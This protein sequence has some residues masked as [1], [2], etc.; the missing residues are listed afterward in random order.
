MSPSHTESLLRKHLPEIS[1][2]YCLDL[3]K[4]YPFVL[5]LKKSRTTRVGDFCMRQGSAPIITLNQDL[6]PFLFL[7]TYIHEFSHHAVWMVYGRK[8]LPHGKE[9][10]LAFKTFMEP[11][12]GMNIFPPDLQARLSHHLVNP[13]ASS[14]SDQKL[15]ALFRKYDQQWAETLILQQIAEGQTFRIKSRVFRKGKKRRTRF[16]CV[17]VR[18]GRLYL[19]PADLPITEFPPPES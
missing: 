8:P 14:F 15:T 2:N 11:I 3:W 9:W 10:K 17:E 7:V 19:V 12:M 5:Q 16:E 13:K 1:V 18:T 6:S 4:R